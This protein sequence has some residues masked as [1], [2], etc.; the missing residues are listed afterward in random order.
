MGAVLD[1]VLCR[2][3]A[4]LDT[5]TCPPSA[6]V[7]S[8]HR[9]HHVFDVEAFDASKGAKYVANP[10]RMVQDDLS[11]TR[12][13][14]CSR[15]ILGKTNGQSF[16]ED[17]ERDNPQ[18]AGKAA[19]RARDA[20]QEHR[21]D[22]K[23]RRRYRRPRWIA[24]AVAARTQRPRDLH[25]GLQPGA[26]GLRQRRPGVIQTSSR[27]PRGACAAAY[28]FRSSAFSARRFSGE[29]SVG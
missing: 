19:D 21:D 26:V 1:D 18:P 9:V 22:R 3:R 23:R 28:P 16:D 27:G 29:Y 8:Q 25:D 12:D 5:T 15:L 6:L 10:H 20:P 7:H 14:T 11:P 2:L 13:L 24:L 4:T 17:C